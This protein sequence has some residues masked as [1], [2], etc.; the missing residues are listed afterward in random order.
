MNYEF[1][2]NFSTSFF[3][4]GNF[5]S[6]SFKGFLIHMSGS[7]DYSIISSFQFR[8]TCIC[9]YNEYCNNNICYPCNP[10]CET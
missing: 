1:R 4:I 7:N 6:V 9:D 3:L 10:D 8:S 5:S 2:T